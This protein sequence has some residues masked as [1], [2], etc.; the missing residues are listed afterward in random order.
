MTSK[1]FETLGLPSDQNSLPI[2]AAPDNAPEN[3]A[4]RL[5]NCASRSQDRNDWA[6]VRVVH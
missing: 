1:L 5:R 6:R 3:G 2:D 4:Q